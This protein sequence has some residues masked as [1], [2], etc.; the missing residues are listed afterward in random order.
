MNKRQTYTN[1][2]AAIGPSQGEECVGDA[3]QQQQQGDLHARVSPFSS[4]SPIKRTQ[5]HRGDIYKKNKPIRGSLPAPAHP[6]WVGSRVRPHTLQLTPTP[7][8][9]KREIS[10]SA[11][12]NHTTT[13][14]S[15]CMHCIMPECS[16]G[17][18]SSVCLPN[19]LISPYQRGIMYDLIS[20]RMK[21]WEAGSKHGERF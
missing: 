3:K 8:T 2:P 7:P 10:K 19:G 12:Q 20:D 15:K 13:K 21:R 1:T 4:P 5:H 17:L 14:T 11:F 6:Q 16:Y 9:C 18:N